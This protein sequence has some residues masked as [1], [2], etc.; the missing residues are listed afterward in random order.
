MPKGA[1]FSWYPYWAK[2][3]QSVSSSLFGQDMYNQSSFG[4]SLSLYLDAFRSIFC[5][6]S[7]P[8]GSPLYKIAIFSK[9]P[10]DPLLSAVFPS[11]NTTSYL[12]PPIRSHIAS[13][14]LIINP[15]LRRKAKAHREVLRMNRS[16]STVGFGDVAAV[17]MGWWTLKQ[18]RHAQCAAISDVT[19]AIS[20][21]SREKLIAKV[22]FSPI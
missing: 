19:T 2:K 12:L 9:H 20:R 16:M 18:V 3:M 10:F 14:C 8:T 6:S 15:P 7:S 21:T 1:Q 11:F 17:A 4:E 5:F 13:S 22:L